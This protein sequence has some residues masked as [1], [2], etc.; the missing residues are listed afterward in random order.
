MRT[1]VYRYV[2]VYRSLLI[3]T[4][5]LKTSIFTAHVTLFSYGSKMEITEAL[6]IKCMKTVY[7]KFLLEPWNYDTK[8]NNM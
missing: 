6:V 3:I 2:I 5:R 8:R 7:I 1:N 4:E